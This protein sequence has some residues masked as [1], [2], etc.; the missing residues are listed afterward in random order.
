MRKGNRSKQM[1]QVLVYLVLAM[2]VTACG[3]STDI[4]DEPV[5]TIE[6]PTQA[7]TLVPTPIAQPTA[8]PLPP[9]HPA[10]GLTFSNFEGL[11]W[12][13]RQGGV[14]LLI[15]QTW[16]VVSQDGKR[17]LYELTDPETNLNDIWLLEIATGERVNL[18]NTPDRDEVNPSWWP[19]RLDV[20]VFGSDIR[21]GM[22]NSSYPTT[23]NVDGNGYQV[24]DAEHGGPFAVS[25]D[26][27][28]I[29]Y[30]S[31]GGTGF[32][33]R[34][35]VG[36]ETFDP[37]EFGVSVE[38]L[39]ASAWSPGGRYLAWKVSGDFWENGSS[40][41]GMAVFDLESKT[42]NLFHV[43]QPVGGGMVPHYIEWSPNS[44]WLAF[45]M[46]NEDAASGRLP[47]LWVARPDGSDEVKIAQGALPF[48]RYDDQYLAFLQADE[49]FNQEIWLAETGTW[50]VSKVSDLPLPETIQLLRGWVQP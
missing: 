17:V 36:S 19:G 15:D 22:E 31:F 13:N 14:E 12:I 8:T 20:I 25:F 27:Q 49:N 43:Y 39:F 35:G 30:G 50:E 2:F 44:E 11:W 6:E 10:S 21:S 26:G 34:W 41:I 48:W 29:A 40:Q 18:T 47:S 24:L 3:P 32:I 28:A 45:V 7:S 4:G 23:V 38:K 9:A 16:G 42:A 33:Y 1:I 46:F 37:S 5:A